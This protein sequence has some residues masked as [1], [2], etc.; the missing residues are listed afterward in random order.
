ME[1]GNVAVVI[2][3]E[4]VL[5]QYAQ[6]IIAK[7]GTPTIAQGESM[8]PVI[9]PNELI[10]FEPLYTSYLTIGSI[11]LFTEGNKMIIKRLV[12]I[13]TAIMG[14]V[15]GL[16]Y[17]FEGDN[18]EKSIDKKVFVSSNDSV[19]TVFKKVVL[20]PQIKVSDN[21]VAQLLGGNK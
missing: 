3:T 21:L 12:D 1:N 9:N 19:K 10:Y 8:Q 17:I 6:E 16:N 13:D 14:G 4:E 7:G 15:K 20:Y 2:D 11:Y 18:R 5:N